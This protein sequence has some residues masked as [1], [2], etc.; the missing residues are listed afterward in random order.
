LNFDDAV[1]T[2]K[3]MEIL[4]YSAHSQPVMAIMDTTQPM[5]YALCNL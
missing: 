2:N 5:A 4:N 1:I 3:A